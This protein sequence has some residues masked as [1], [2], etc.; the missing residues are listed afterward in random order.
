MRKRISVVCACPPSP[1]PGMTAV[2]LAFQGLARRFFPEVDVHYLQLYTEAELGQA[3]ATRRADGKQGMPGDESPLPYRPFR[4]CLDALYA[5]DIIVYW[6]DFMHL[7][8][9][10]ETTA[11][12]LLEIGAVPTLAEGQAVADRHFLL[13]DA[14]DE[15]LGEVLAFGG[16]L[17]FNMLRDYVRGLYARHVERLMRQARRVWMRDVH[18]AL[19]VGHLRGDYDQSYLGMD[20][21][22]LVEGEEL[23]RL[24]RRLNDDSFGRDQIGVFFSRGRLP[25]RKSLG[26]ARELSRRSG[27]GAFWLPWREVRRLRAKTFWP[28]SGLVLPTPGQVPALGD[29]FDCIRRCS[30]IVTDTYHLAVN[31]WHLGTPA[32]CIGDDWAPAAWDVSCGPGAAWRDKRWIFMSMYNALPFYVHAGEMSDRGW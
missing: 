12:R 14:S 15:V 30:L 7:A 10:R 21:A 2:D 24:P 27:R 25:L 18:S 23:E 8:R 11:R 20:C 32:I 5:S 31:A 16:N 9:Y 28:F 4:H 3:R 1:N 26:L 6:G 17:L 19:S 29:C 22:L 13:T